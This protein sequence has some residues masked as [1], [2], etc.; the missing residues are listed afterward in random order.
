VRSLAPLLAALLLPAFAWAGPTLRAD[1]HPGSPEQLEL[2]D[3]VWANCSSCHGARGEGRPG[4]APRLA[5]DELLS[6]VG[7]AFLRRAVAEGRTGTWMPPWGDRL[8]GAEIDA[9]V[10]HI[11]SW[12]TRDGVPLDRSPL[13]G[14]A[15]QGGRDFQ[16]RCASCHGPR[17]EG[18]AMGWVGPAIGGAAFLDQADDPTLRGL[19][20]HGRPGT[21][22]PPFPD[23]PGG[24]DG[25][26]LDGVVRWLR[27]GAWE[28]I[29]WPERPAAV[30][31]DGAGSS[32]PPAAERPWFGMLPGLSWDS[33]EGL[34]IGA[35][36][37]LGGGDAVEWSIDLS[38][39]I[40][41]RPRQGRPP[42]VTFQYHQLDLYLE[43]LAGGALALGVGGGFFQAADTPW[44]G[45]GN[46]ST[47]EDLLLADPAFYEVDHL[48]P[49][50]DLSAAVELA[51]PPPGRLELALTVNTTWNRVRLHPGSLLAKEAAAGRVDADPG[52]VGVTTAGLLWDGTDDEVDPTRGIAAEASVR[53]GLSRAGTGGPGAFG[54]THLSARLY[55]PAV[56]G[57]LV[58][59][60]RL[61][62]DLSWGDVPWYMLS[63]AGGLE[64]A[65][66]TGGGSS[67]RGVWADRRAGRIKVLSNVELRVYLA[68]FQLFGLPVGLS[69]VTFLDAGRVWTP[70]PALDGEGLGLAT[71]LGAGARL[72]LGEDLIIRLDGAWSPG[73][74]TS[75]VYLDFGHAF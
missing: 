45:L 2:G 30:G 8:S 34:S 15:E 50:L 64:V 70:D 55:L 4:F 16:A 37:W 39:W 51:R 22:M 9:V 36:A 20:R 68:R 14:S 44:Y 24:L 53:G 17:G 3:R 65:E 40:G 71:G 46:A 75:G 60:T 31:R 38:S 32:G 6:V 1:Q 43:G 35:D 27:A 18:M 48:A 28:D 13:Q 61:A 52:L 11:R 74:G 63:Q 72:H 66:A 19:V 73:D 67:I 12:Q 42:A 10:A 47:V 5:S 33:E 58:L 57:R 59:A 26:R 25:E 56:E 69:A 41:L 23:G 21:P 49:W 7:D 29:P 62:A 54:G